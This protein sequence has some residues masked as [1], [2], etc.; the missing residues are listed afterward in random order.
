MPTALVLEDDRDLRQMFSEAL[1][2]S[3]FDVVSA[4]TVPEAIA[5]LADYSPQIAFVD[6]NLP[7][8]QSG[9]DLVRYIRSQAHLVATKVVVVTANRQMQDIAEQMDIDLFLLKPVS[10]AEMLRLAQR[11]ISQTAC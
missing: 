11:L 2:A 1:Q 9:M 4:G 5:L 8:Q 7:D 10:I 6:M 3:G